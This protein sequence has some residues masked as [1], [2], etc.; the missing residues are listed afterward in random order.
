MMLVQLPGIVPGGQDVPGDGAGGHPHGRGLPEGLG[1]ADGLGE[2]EELGVGVG[3][4]V[5][6]SEKTL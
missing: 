1:E 5:C 2:G 6:K 4:H 3:E